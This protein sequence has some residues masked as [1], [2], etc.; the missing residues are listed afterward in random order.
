MR[1][2]ENG[3]AIP[4]ELLHARDE[5]R[6]VFFCGAGVSQAKAGLPGFFGLAEEVM[7]TLGV[8]A[9]SPAQKLLKEARNFEAQTGVA[10]VIPADRIF[11]PYWLRGRR[12]SSRVAGVIAADR[13]FGLLERE[14]FSTDDIEKAVASALRP[15]LQPNG[16]PDLTAHR[17]I[18]DLATTREGLVHVVTTN[19]DCL[20]DRL[21]DDCGRDLSSWQRPRLPDPSRPKDMDGIVYLHGKVTSDYQGAEGDGF[22]LSSSQ[23]GQAYLS[24]GWATSFFREIIESYVVVFVGYTADDPPVHY[25][26]EGLNRQ[27]K[28][29][30]RQVYA[31]QPGN[32]DEATSKWRAQRGYGHSL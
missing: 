21:F 12:R 10:G 31:F 1:F 18:L 27:I 29:K 17:I 28:D 25:L 6:V 4:D 15:K 5:G 2:F 26:L 22:V 11:G 8:Q 7:K 23:F 16:K 30:E 19:F 20:F 3:P 9:D 13:I 32:A 14:G 24:E